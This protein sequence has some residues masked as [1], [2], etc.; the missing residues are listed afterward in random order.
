[1]SQS[2]LFSETGPFNG[3]LSALWKLSRALG[4]PTTEIKRG[5]EK[6]R[7]RAELRSF[8]PGKENEFDMSFEQ[9]RGALTASLKLQ[10]KAQ[11]KQK[12]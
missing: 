10:G 8:I 5:R 9:K 6:I 1:M 7:E 3:F 4:L 12:K 2:S 11:E